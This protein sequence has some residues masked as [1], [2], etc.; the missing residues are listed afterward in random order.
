[1]ISDFNIQVNK[2][3]KPTKVPELKEKNSF[4]LLKWLIQLISDRP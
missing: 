3:A 1:M 2:A 4:L